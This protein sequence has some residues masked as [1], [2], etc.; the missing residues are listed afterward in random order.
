MPAHR[1]INSDQQVNRAIKAAPAKVKRSRWKRTNCETRDVNER[2]GMIQRAPD[3]QN[4]AN[5]A[6]HARQMTKAPRQSCVGL[7]ENDSSAARKSRK[8]HSGE[9]IFF[10]AENP[11]RR[12][13]QTRSPRR[14]KSGQD[15]D[16]KYPVPG[17]GLGQ[18][19]ADTR[20]YRGDHGDSARHRGSQQRDVSRAASQRRW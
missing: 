10:R 8:Q 11:P 3:R 13:A 17:I 9:S 7:V 18:I 14:E 16:Q 1:P 4:A 19:T 15:I 12:T 2:A 6:G 20:R 5:R